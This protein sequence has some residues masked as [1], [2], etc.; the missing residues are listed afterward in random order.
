MGSCKVHRLTAAKLS[1]SSL[2]SLKKTL[3]IIMNK[4][5]I[6]KKTQSENKRMS[7]SFTF[8]SRKNTKSKT[9]KARNN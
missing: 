9:K 8:K 2:T 1:S 4:G 3:E 5:K 6:Y 7:K